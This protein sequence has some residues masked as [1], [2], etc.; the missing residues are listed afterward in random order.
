MSD[1]KL[2]NIPAVV[3]YLDCEGWKISKSAAYKH[4]KEGKLRPGSS[5]QFTVKA[6]NKYA[7]QWLE[8]K[9]GS[10]DALDDLQEQRATAEL[11]KL[12]AQ[13]RHW[14][15]KAN[16][17]QG[18]YVSKEEWDRELASRAKIFRSDI[19]N[20]IRQRAFDLISL[21][22]GDGA[23]APELVDYYL[24]HVEI[25]MNRYT[26]DQSWKVPNNK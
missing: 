23:K 1:E 15:I 11:E 25:W 17:E 2:K 7:A 14:D 9:D 24:K 6:V 19:E 13:A 5:G 3:D 12:Q 4:K 21:V 8:K 18:K 26:R 16:I 22:N 20:F 10:A